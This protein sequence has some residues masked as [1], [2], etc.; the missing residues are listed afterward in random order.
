MGLAE[1]ST[2]AYD[3]WRSL[4]LLAV[5]VRVFYRARNLLDHLHDR[6][7]QVNPWLHFCSVVFPTKMP[8]IQAQTWL[9]CG[10]SDAPVEALKTAAVSST[11]HTVEIVSCETSN[12]SVREKIDNKDQWH[13]THSKN[14]STSC[15]C[16]C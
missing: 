8:P 10:V 14:R 4:E 2:S 6:A 7:G 15:S 5:F 13:T 16:H 9:Y 1:A 12:T 3:G 11:V